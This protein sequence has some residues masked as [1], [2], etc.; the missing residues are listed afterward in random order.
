MRVVLQSMTNY[1]QGTIPEINVCCRIY[2]S[3]AAAI[4]PQ[5]VA[6]HISYGN[7]RL[8]KLPEPFPLDNFRYCLVHAYFS[9]N[10]HLVYRSLYPTVDCFRIWTRV[11]MSV[12]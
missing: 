3:N 9:S 6:G 5:P 4:M 2:T 1:N 10:S 11:N 7:I 8:A 12:N